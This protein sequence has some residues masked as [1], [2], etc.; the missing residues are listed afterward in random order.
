MDASDTIV[1]VDRSDVRDGALEAVRAAI[2][3]LAEFI[4]AHEPQLLAYNVYLNEDGTRMTVIHV[5]RDS[6][7]LEYHLDVGGPAFRKFADL[8]TLR[9]ID[10]YGRPSEAALERLNEKAR[11]L[12]G[13]TVNVLEWRAGFVRPE[14]DR[15]Y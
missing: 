3:E 1:Y 15:E 6:A 13:A 2:D 4:E 7:S 12:G 5:N 10:V 14:D 9:S 11:M 8:I